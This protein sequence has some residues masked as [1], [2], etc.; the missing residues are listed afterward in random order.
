MDMAETAC[1]HPALIDV[2]AARVADGGRPTQRL[3]DH[4]VALVIEGGGMRGTVSAG[5]ALELHLLGLTTAFDAVYGSSA[6]AISAAW[7][8]SEHPEGL[9]GW[10]DPRFATAL[11]SRRNLLRGRPLVDVEQLIED[12]YVN[13]F[14][15]PYASVLTNP[16]EFHALATDVVSGRAVDLAPWIV[17]VASLKRALRASA[18]LPILAGRAVPLGDSSYYDAGLA[19]SIP[20]R[21]ALQ[22]GATHVLVLRSK[23]AIDVPGQDSA[24]TSSRVLVATGFRGWTE[25]LRAAYLSRNE[26]SVEDDRRL[27]AY[28]AV[29]NPTVVSIRPADDSPRVGRLESRGEVLREAFRGGRAAVRARLG[30][31]ATGPS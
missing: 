31:L 21:R 18:A 12:V 2:L 3:D 16:I 8:L 7:L 4:R 29:E 23:R 25:E 10:S 27:D 17:D 15:L 28:Q 5:M 1:Q 6:G 20:Y 19:E 9:E 14:V 11:I 13:D 24:T 26:R 30:E 22:D